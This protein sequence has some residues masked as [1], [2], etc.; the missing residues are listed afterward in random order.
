VNY[1]LIFENQ[2]K[3]DKITHLL[4]ESHNELKKRPRSNDDEILKISKKLEDIASFKKTKLNNIRK[5][6]M[7][8][9]EN[10]LVSANISQKSGCEIETHF[11]TLLT[12]IYSVFD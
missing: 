12:D 11:R 1:D 6:R 3:N 7:T 4:E 8:E 9:L 10:I 2:R 5:S